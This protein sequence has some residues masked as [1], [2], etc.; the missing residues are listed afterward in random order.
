MTEA[1]TDIIV[2]RSRQTDRLQMMLV[3]SVAAHLVLVAAML[4]IP[5]VTTEPPPREIMTISLGGAPGPRTGGL[6][7]AA[8]RSV[9]APTPP[10]PVRRAETAPAPTPPPMTLPD[11]RAKTRPP[12]TRPDR[13][14]TEATGRTPTTGAQPSEGNAK[15]DTRV[16][17]QGFG[18]STSGGLGAGVQLDVTDFCC[19]EY[20]QEMVGL[21]QRNWQKDQGV[22]GSTVMKFTI[23]RDGTIDMIQVE[24]PSGFLA[25][26]NAAL[27][28][29][30]LT[31]RL[32]PLPAQYPNPTLGVRLT[33]EYQR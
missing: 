12:R 8:G 27:R 31:R 20:L 15:A 6:T 1:V 22:V 14:P 9:Q 30:G 11:P 16:R 19:Q 18:L 4:W 17:G 23:L 26:D 7:Q 24:R 25:L 5:R 33:F 10:E 29:L 32:P 21:I 13:A 28:A 3:W 2:A